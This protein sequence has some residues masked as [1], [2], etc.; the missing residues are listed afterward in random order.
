MLTKHIRNRHGAGPGALALDGSRQKAGN[1]HM[2]PELQSSAEVTVA[3]LQAVP[4]RNGAKEGSRTHAGGGLKP[5]PRHLTDRLAELA[6]I[7]CGKLVGEQALSVAMGSVEA[8]D[9]VAREELGHGGGGGGARSDVKVQR[10]P[11]VTCGGAVRQGGD[12]Q[13]VAQAGAGEGGGDRHSLVGA[14]KERGG[15]APAA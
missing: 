3:E 1:G 15:S 12:M 6:L 7:A 8:L 14:L 10:E 9:A 13:L 4:D 11:G 5:A 2:Q